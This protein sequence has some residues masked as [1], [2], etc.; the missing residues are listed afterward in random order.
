MTKTKKVMLRIAVLKIEAY[1]LKDSPQEYIKRNTWKP[2][3]Q[4]CNTCYRASKYDCS[5]ECFTDD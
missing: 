2:K 5:P 4:E 1:K 3:F